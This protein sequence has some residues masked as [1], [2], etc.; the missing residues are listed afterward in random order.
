VW[1][2]LLGASDIIL[3]PYDPNR[4]RAAYSA[5]AVEAVANAIPLVGP[6][7][8]SIERLIQECGDCGTVFEEFEENSIAAATI[9]AIDD[10]DRYASAAYSA[11]E[12]CPN[13]YG[14]DRLVDA[15][16]AF[17]LGLAAADGGRPPLAPLGSASKSQSPR[18]PGGEPGAAVAQQEGAMP[19]STSI[20]PELNQLFVSMSSTSTAMS[21]DSA[22]SKRSTSTSQGRNV[23]RR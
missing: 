11:A 20:A 2:E 22:N 5:V 19:D 4:F 15:L 6:A 9:L 8:S 13:Q 1:A 14:P 17:G 16:L 10:L 3:C 21:N 7:G 18:P 12:Q 23:S